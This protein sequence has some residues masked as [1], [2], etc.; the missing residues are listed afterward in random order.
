MPTFDGNYFI[1]LDA[2]DLHAPM[3]ERDHAV[4]T[5]KLSIPTVGNDFSSALQYLSAAAADFAGR[6][7]EERQHVR[8]VLRKDQIETGPVVII[9]EDQ[10]RAVARHPDT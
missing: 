1:I 4:W 8:P 7:T 6:K 3:A 9:N 2:Y 5:V 10:P